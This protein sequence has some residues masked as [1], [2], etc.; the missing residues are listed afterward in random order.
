MAVDGANM[1]GTAAVA[2]GGLVPMGD[3]LAARVENGAGALPVGAV[4]ADAVGE[5]HRVGSIDATDEPGG[6]GPWRPH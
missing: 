5:V 2:L 1:V 4:G 3:D 6:Y